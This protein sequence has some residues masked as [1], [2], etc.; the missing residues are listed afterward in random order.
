METCKPVPLVASQPIVGS[1][2]SLLGG[3]QALYEPRRL[4]CAALRNLVA[5]VLFVR[6]KTAE[7]R[8]GLLGPY[9]WLGEYRHP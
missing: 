5:E 3:V 4:P 7:P 6:V 9:A 8:G 2:E 1:Q